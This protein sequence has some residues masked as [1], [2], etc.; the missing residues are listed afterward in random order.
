VHKAKHMKMVGSLFG[1]GP[2]AR[3]P[4]DTPLNPALLTNA[5]VLIT[6]IRR[7]CYG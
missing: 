6:K 5:S 4:W 1:G 2:C 7:Y 3:V